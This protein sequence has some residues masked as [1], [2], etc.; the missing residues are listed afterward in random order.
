MTQA[1]YRE[2]AVHSMIERVCGEAVKPAGEITPLS[3]RRIESD[4]QDK[5]KSGSTGGTGLREM[6]RGTGFEPVT[7]SV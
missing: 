2:N 4:F 5:K 3:L 7:P 1:S 6:V